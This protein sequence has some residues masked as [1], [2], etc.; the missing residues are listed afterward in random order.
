MKITDVKTILLTGPSS[1]DP[2]LR[3]VCGVRSAA[4]I[5]LHTDTELVGLGETYA[6]YLCPELVPPL[7]EF[8]APILIGQTIDDIPEL[9]RR[10]YHCGNYWGRV[11][12]GAIVMGGIDAALWDLKGKADRVPVFELLGG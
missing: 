7:V 8:Y 3:E 10:L 1:E 5:E 12:L 9:W 6:G 11:G 4:F 2:S